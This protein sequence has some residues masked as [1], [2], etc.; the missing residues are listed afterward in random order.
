[1]RDT[2][3]TWGGRGGGRGAGCAGRRGH[4]TPAAQPGTPG[5]PRR[6]RSHKPQGSAHSEAA[7]PC[8]PAQTR[9]SPGSAGRTLSCPRPGRVPSTT[10][11][12]GTADLP[13]GSRGSAASPP[14][15]PPL[16]LLRPSP[17]GAGSGPRG[18]T[19]SGEC[20]S[21]GLHCPARLSRATAMQTGRARTAPLP[22]P[23][24]SGL[25]RGLR[26][27]LGGPRSRV[28]PRASSCPHSPAPAGWRPDRT[29]P[30]PQAPGSSPN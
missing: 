28:R 1:M 8:P 29:A 12:V 19:H 11:P 5:S 23:S 24:S 7:C 6:P 15:S 25:A 21:R 14:G 4:G 18:Q 17:R 27:R 20:P 2:F 26:G 3:G 10:Y 16:R 30:A 13:Q 22:P 9:G